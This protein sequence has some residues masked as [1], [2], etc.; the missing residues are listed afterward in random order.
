MKFALLAL[1]MLSVPAAAGDAGPSADLQVVISAHGRTPKGPLEP[2]AAKVQFIDTVVT[3]VGTRPRTIVAWT[4]Y[5]W[6][7]VSNSAQVSPGIE[8]MK[9]APKTIVLEPGKSFSRGVEVYVVGAR[10]VTFRLGFY[11]T[12]DVPVSGRVPPLANASLFWS[13]ALTLH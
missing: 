8:A 11:P 2:F 12:A 13:N 7:W 4:Q 3:N 5:G 6:S 1:C 9:N 10:P